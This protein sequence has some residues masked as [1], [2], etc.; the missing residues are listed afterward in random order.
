MTNPFFVIKISAMQE[1]CKKVVAMLSI[2]LVVFACLFATSCAPASI[3]KMETNLSLDNYKSYISV[4]VPGFGKAGDLVITDVRIRRL[5]GVQLE[6]VEI[7]YT[8]NATEFS[9]TI[10]ENVGNL[11]DYHSH[12]I[13]FTYQ[14]SLRDINISVD[15]TAISGTII[16]APPSPK[17]PPVDWVGILGL[18]AASIFL[19][20]SIV[21]FVFFIKR[22]AAFSKKVESIK[23]GMTYNEVVQLLDK[24]ET[25]TTAEG[26]KTCIWSRVVIRGMFNNHIITFKNDKVIAVNDHTNFWLA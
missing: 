14:M 21:M 3:P 15:V 1:K 18:I 8:F 24:P 12:E 25:S 5:A 10:T 4:Y 7:T 6:N 19:V 22:A 17:E 26:I 13:R 11:R 9:Q 23:I 16:S 2:M 20:L